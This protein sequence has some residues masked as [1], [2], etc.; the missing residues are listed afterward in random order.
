MSTGYVIGGAKFAQLFTATN[1]TSPTVGTTAVITLGKQVSTDVKFDTSGNPVVTVDGIQDNAAMTTYLETYF[2][3]YSG[4]GEDITFEDASTLTASGGNPVQLGIF[5]GGK[6]ADSSSSSYGARK[7]FVGL[8][9]GSA[10]SGSWKQE[11]NK[12]NRPTLVYNGVDLEGTL[13]IVT[14]MFLATLCSTPAQV[15]LTAAHKKGKVVWQ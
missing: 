1:G 13:T 3:T 10:E 6:D 15:V 11:G 2:H 4:T 14:T 8:I 9:R 7:I 5:Y 12:Y